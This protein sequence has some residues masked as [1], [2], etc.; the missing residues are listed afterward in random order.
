[1]H[2]HLLSRILFSL[3]QTVLYYVVIAGVFFAMWLWW[4]ARPGK[5]QPLPLVSPHPSSLDQ[6]QSLVY[7][8]HQSAGSPGG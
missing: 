1:M 6:H 3:Q 8:F 2:H 7:L 4:R 5:R